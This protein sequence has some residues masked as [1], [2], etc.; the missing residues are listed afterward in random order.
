MDIKTE[1]AAEFRPRV[2]TTL[3]DLDEL[4]I[5]TVIYDQGIGIAAQRFEEG[6]F[7]AGGHQGYTSE[8]YARM[9]PVVVLYDP[10][11]ED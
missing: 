4:P 8:V 7:Q 11:K 5:Y 3:E 9:L 6:W 1:G 2:V 10:A